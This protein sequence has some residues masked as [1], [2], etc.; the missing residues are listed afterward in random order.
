MATT[1]GPLS[2]VTTSSTTTVEARPVGDRLRSRA[3]EGHLP[4]FQAAGERDRRQRRGSRERTA[5]E[6]VPGQFMESLDGGDTRAGAKAVHARARRAIRSRARAELEHRRREHAIER[7]AAGDGDGS[8]GH[9]SLHVITSSFT[10]IRTDR[11]SVSVAAGQAVALYRR[12]AADEWNTVHE[13]T[14]DGCIASA[15]AKKPWVVA[16]DEQGPANLGVPPDPGYSG[17]AGKDVKGVD[18]GYTLHDIRKHRCGA[19]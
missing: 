10:R 8:Q 1:S 16:N 2:P 7:A 4:A 6:T 12:V 15:Q 13:R 5:T 17:F 19:I 11:K 3:A 9:R 14:L 18:V